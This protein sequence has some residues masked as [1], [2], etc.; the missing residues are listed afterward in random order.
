MALEDWGLPKPRRYLCY[1]AP[2][3]LEMTGSL[4]KAFWKAAPWTEEFV[5]IEGDLRP[6]PR[7]RTRVKML[8][9]D[10]FLYIGAEMEE[11]NVWATL[12]EHDTVIFQ[13]NDFEVFIDPDG[14][15]HDYYELEINALNT[16]WDLRLVK[17]YRDGGPALN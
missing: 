4:E 12:T 6:A 10:E 11:P 17:P 7:F 3:A 1:R 2:G 5:D 13:D 15:N 8:W 9:D 16:T 14:D